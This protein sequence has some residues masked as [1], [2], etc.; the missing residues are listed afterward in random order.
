MVR[1]PLRSM[2][3][4][5]GISERF[6]AKA[7][8][9]PA[10]A[11]AFDLEDSVA[12]VDKAA[13]RDLVARTLTEFPPEGRELWVRPNA[14]DSG[15]LEADLD[16]VVATGLDGLHLPKADDAAT[17]AQVDHYLTYLEAVRG[18]PAGSTLLMA[19]IESAAGLSRVEEIC[20]SSPRLVG[21]SLGSEDYTASLGVQRTRVGAELA[22]ARGRLANAAAAA[23]IRAIDG[24]EAD[25][26]DPRL[27]ARQA[28]VARGVGFGGKFCIHPDQVALAHEVFAPT[29]RERARALRVVGAFEA[30]GEGAGAIAVD[31]VMVD[32]PVYLRALRLLAR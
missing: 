1:P 3:S 14:L 24:P 22:H 20:R 18:L 28:R 27:F 17:V 10:D 30:A 2:L 5:P 8:A 26:R 19:W 16:A 31:G 9:V 29:E 25:F 7:R 13:A 4:V 12:A 15:L 6:M 11:I 23:G 32:R 21:V